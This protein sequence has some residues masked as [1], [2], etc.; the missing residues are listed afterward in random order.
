M[1]LDK[2]FE[3]GVVSLGKYTFPNTL[4]LAVKVDAFP[5]KHDEKKLQKALPVRCEYPPRARWSYCP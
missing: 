5:T 4:A 2:T 1:A 3:I